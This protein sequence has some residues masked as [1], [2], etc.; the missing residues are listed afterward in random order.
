MKPSDFIR[1]DEKTLGLKTERPATT[2]YES[3]WE[4]R[5]RSDDRWFFISVSHNLS[6]YRQVHASI[7]FPG[8]PAWLPDET[9]EHL[10]SLLRDDLVWER[11][12]GRTLMT[13]V[14]EDENGP[15]RDT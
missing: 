9:I 3:F 14:P 8:S 1:V 10:L 7:S 12:M 15:E 13:V 5:R 2:I 11:A 6:G 4:Y